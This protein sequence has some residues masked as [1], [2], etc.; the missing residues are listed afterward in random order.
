MRVYL[1]IAGDRAAENVEEDR[2]SSGEDSREAIFSSGKS[3]SENI[4][5]R[6]YLAP[7]NRIDILS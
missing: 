4:R 2:S 5:G 6:E 1:E 7:L 3:E